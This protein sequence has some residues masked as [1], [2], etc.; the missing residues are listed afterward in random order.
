M[1]VTGTPGSGKTT[2]VAY[3]EQ[4]GDK[5]FIDADEVVGLCEWR[6]FE[7][8]KVIGLVAEVT[9]TGGD[10]WYKKHGWY[11]VEDRLKQFLA[12][13]PNAIICGSSENIAD[14]YRLFS[15]IIILRKTEAELLKNLQS[16][17]RAN[18]FGK[19]TKQRSGFMK[20]QDYLIK[21]AQSYPVCFVD[22][23]LIEDVYQKVMHWQQVLLL[24]KS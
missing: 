6:E 14:C 21:Q 12:D 9:I 4:K 18:P 17:D 3:S 19:T 13:N 8:D 1:L 7:T 22:G 11:W 23:N 16:P 5:R 20:W 2:L 24:I 15:K 10:D